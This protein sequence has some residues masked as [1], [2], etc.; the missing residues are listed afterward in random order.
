MR[1]AQEGRKA[2]ALRYK[3]GTDGAPRV[4]AAGKGFVAE[5]IIA[6]ARE[7][8]VPI[9]GDE[10]LVQALV[11]L[12]LCQEIPVELYAAV[13]EILAFVYRLDRR[14]EKNR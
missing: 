6:R 9:H 14:R 2:A 13:A 7:A 8:G 10:L 11:E 5:K 12:D 4:V 1:G 3:P